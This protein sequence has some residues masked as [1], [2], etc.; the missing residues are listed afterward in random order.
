M[1]EQKTTNFKAGEDVIVYSDFLNQRR[2]LGKAMLD[3]RLGDYPTKNQ[4]ALAQ[5]RV[6]FYDERGNLETDDDKKPVFSTM[7]ILEV[8]KPNENR[9]QSEDYSQYGAKPE[10]DET[11]EVVEKK[12]PEKKAAPSTG[13][14]GRGRP[15]VPMNEIKARNIV[16]QLKDKKRDG[17]LDEAVD[18]L[19][20]ECPKAAKFVEKY[21]EY[22]DGSF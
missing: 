5:W 18:Y 1:S 4:W 11:G 13:S 8:G 20:N 17:R 12:K 21:L 14:R 9:P 10:A 6:R 16:R 15:E 19:L 22:L 3:E 7:P 2:P